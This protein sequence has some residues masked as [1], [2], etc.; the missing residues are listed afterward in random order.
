MTKKELP[1]LSDEELGDVVYQFE[2]CALPYANWTH[3]AHLAVAIF[4]SRELDYEAALAK[5]RKNINAYN[6]ACGDPNGYNETI[7]MMF[8]KKIYAE[9]NGGN[10]CK[11]MF[12]EVERIKALCSAEWLFR[13]FTPDVIFSD[14]AKQIWVEPDVQHLDF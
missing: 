9:F 7:T 8:M 2:Q 1:I 12:R 3:R 14:T 4:Y 6:L 10:A 5:I 11:T 13:Y